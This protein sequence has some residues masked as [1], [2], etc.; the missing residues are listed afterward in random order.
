MVLPTARA[1]KKNETFATKYLLVVLIPAVVI[2]ERRASLGD[3][4]VGCLHFTPCFP[5]LRAN[6]DVQTLAPQK[7][8]SHGTCT[9]ECETNVPRVGFLTHR[10]HVLLE[11]AHIL[12]NAAVTFLQVVELQVNSGLGNFDAKTGGGGDLPAKGVK[13]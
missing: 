3:A 1:T 7:V 4:H 9:Q 12:R 8:L 2:R 5:Q 6:C 13:R 10:L 11:R